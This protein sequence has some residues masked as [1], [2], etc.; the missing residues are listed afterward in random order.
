MSI[1]GLLEFN[2]NIIRRCH[3]RYP[4]L[5]IEAWAFKV[6]KQIDD[7]YSIYTLKSIINL[8]Y[9]ESPVCYSCVA[10]NSRKEESFIPFDRIKEPEFVNIL[11]SISTI[12][13]LSEQISKLFE[14]SM[15]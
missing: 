7:S 1:D 3:C 11:K 2:P 10:V 14:K 5:L 8:S 4:N 9:E 15:S 12:N 6:Y 13:S